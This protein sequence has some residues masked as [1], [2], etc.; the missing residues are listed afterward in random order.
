MELNNI[1]AVGNETP[2]TLASGETR[3]RPTTPE[4]TVESERD[5]LGPSDPIA[6]DLLKLYDDEGTPAGLVGGFKGVSRPSRPTSSDSHYF[7][8]GGAW[9]GSR[10]RST[11]EEPYVFSVAQL[12]LGVSR[13]SL[14]FRRLSDP[15][16]SGLLRRRPTDPPL[17]PPS[18]RQSCFVGGAQAVTAEPFD[19]VKSEDAPMPAKRTA[20]GERTLGGGGGGGGA[21]RIPSSTSPL[22]SVSRAKGPFLCLPESSMRPRSQSLGCTLLEAIAEESSMAVPKT[23]RRYSSPAAAESRI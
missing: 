2:P 11:I 9:Q 7:S 10:R 6:F 3:L 8:G 5:C 17:S 15:G 23:N 19:P 16:T 14:D 20:A 1:G 13:A 12:T 21:R 4:I 22:M 18:T